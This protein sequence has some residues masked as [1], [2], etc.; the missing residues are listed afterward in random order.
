MPRRPSIGGRLVASPGG[1]NMV[2]VVSPHDVLLPGL[3]ENWIV[4][5]YCDKGSLSDHLSAGRLP[6]IATALR[7]REVHVVLCLLD[8]ALGLNY[9][10]SAGIV[11]GDLKPANVLL[12]AARNDRRGFVCKLGDF[13]LSR[14]LGQGQSH[15]DTTSYGT[16]S[17]AA[18]ELLKEGRLT[19]AADIY[20]LGIMVW[21]MVAGEPHGGDLTTMQIIL[22]VSQNKYRPQVPA[23]CSPVLGELMQSCWSED[24]ADRPT[25]SALV[26]KLRGLVTPLLRAS[27]TVPVLAASAAQAPADPSVTS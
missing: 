11:H 23:H 26:D 6:P 14:M 3:Y 20:S 10:H 18:P 12:K 21:E 15:V 19:K 16:P 4:M 2:E 9:L 13:G 17:Y 5:E 25:A 27:A 7:Q 22:Q 1:S 8:I 24:P